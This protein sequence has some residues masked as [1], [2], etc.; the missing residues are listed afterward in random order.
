MLA[1]TI[2]AADSGGGGDS[3]G[4]FLVSPGI[5]LM[6][7]TLV[8][9]GLTMLLLAKLAFPRIAEALDRRQKAIEE[10]IDT[11]SAPARRRTGC[12][13]STASASPRPDTRP[14]RSSPA[15][16]RRASSRRPTRS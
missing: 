8:V 7:W 3:G 12:S 11:A 15:R 13:P 1:T 14:T 10:S 16:A 2:I 6:I 4:S 5:G 9:F